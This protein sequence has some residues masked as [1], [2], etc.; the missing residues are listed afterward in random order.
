MIHRL[1]M[2]KDPNG[3]VMQV[4][5][6]AEKGMYVFFDPQSWERIRVSFIPYFYFDL[7]SFASFCKRKASDL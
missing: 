1:W 3:E 6:T 4:S 2:T 5:E 7:E